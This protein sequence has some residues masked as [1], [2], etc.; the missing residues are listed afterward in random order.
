MNFKTY[1]KGCRQI[2]VLDFVRNRKQMQAVAVLGIAATVVMIAAGLILVPFAP[3]WALLKANWW[4]WLVA[5]AMYLAYIPLHELTHGLLMHALSGVKPKYGLKLP[6]AYAGS[7]VYF[8]KTS[9]NVIALAPLLVWGVVLAVLE[10]ALPAGWFWLVYVTQ[11]SNV[12]G[13]MGDVYCV[14]YLS[15][16]PKDVVVQDTGT[17]MRILAPR[18][19]KNEEPK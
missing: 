14:W 15:R 16:L 13:S 17:R 12:S 1:P 6:Y 10:R 3:T 2:A 5:P 8:D 4:A 9:H 18:P 7:H 19:D 11:I